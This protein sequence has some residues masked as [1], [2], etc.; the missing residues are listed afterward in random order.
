MASLPISSALQ[1]SQDVVSR[2]LGDGTVLV[3]LPSNRI[4]ELNDTGARIWELISEGRDDVAAALSEEFSV[5]PA[6]ATEAVDRLVAEL[7]A[8]GLLTPRAGAPS[9]NGSQT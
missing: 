6:A 7:R 5:D 8:E 9:R 4:F 1:P 3:H 2:R